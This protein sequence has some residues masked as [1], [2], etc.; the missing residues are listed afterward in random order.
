MCGYFA[1]YG[2]AADGICVA[3]YQPLNGRNNNGSP[4]AAFTTAGYPGY[5][6]GNWPVDAINDYFR[7][8]SF[9]NTD[10]WNV[11]GSQAPSLPSGTRMYATSPASTIISPIRFRLLPS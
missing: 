11:W 6:S 3:P 8:T 4:V 9:Y 10:N 7:H 1:T 5:P 2:I